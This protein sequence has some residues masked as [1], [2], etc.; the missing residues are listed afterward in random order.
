MKNYFHNFT[1]CLLTATVFAQSPEKNE[2][3]GSNKKQ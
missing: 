2:L 3:S 1:S